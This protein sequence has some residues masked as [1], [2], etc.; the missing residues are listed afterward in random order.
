MKKTLLKF[1]CLLFVVS[2]CIPYAH[3]DEETFGEDQIIESAEYD[4]EQYAGEDEPL[5]DLRDEPA[6]F[7][8]Q[9]TGQDEPSD[10]LPDEPVEY[11]E[12]H[13]LEEER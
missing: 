1:I 6:E 10:D 8:D 9:D 4:E 5:E 7:E 3:A 2:V 11:D 13:P 12:E